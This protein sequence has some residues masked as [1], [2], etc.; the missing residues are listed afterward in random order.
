MVHAV[1]CFGQYTLYRVL[2]T[3]GN[4]VVQVTLQFALAQ[5]IAIKITLMSCEKMGG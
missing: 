2:Q 4:V 5:D 3:L 1:L